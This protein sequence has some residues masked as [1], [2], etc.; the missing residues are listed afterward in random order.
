[1]WPCSKPIRVPRQLHCTDSIHS[2]PSD[3]II[4]QNGL[5]TARSKY[6]REIILVSIIPFA[7]HYSAPRTKSS[8]L[9]GGS[10]HSST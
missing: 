6:H 1:L 3:K 4:K 2:P 10:R 9:I 5:S 8:S 7:I